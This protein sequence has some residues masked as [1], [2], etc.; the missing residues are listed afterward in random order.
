VKSFVSKLHFAVSSSLLLAVATPA[1]AQPDPNPKTTLEAMSSGHHSLQ[2]LGPEYSIQIPV[3]RIE[4]AKLIL[5]NHQLAERLGLQLPSDPAQLEKM[6]LDHFAFTIAKDGEP[7][8]RTW[9]ATYYLDS[10]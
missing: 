2:T 7:S 4:G 1:F 10:N 5:F 6:I 9:M 3:R 8:D